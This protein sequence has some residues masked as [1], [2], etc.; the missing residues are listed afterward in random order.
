MC[1]NCLSVAFDNI[2]FFLMNKKLSIISKLLYLLAGR[3]SLG[4]FKYRCIRFASLTHF[5]LPLLS[6]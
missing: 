1:S 2:T 6:I 4:F 5:Q 3:K